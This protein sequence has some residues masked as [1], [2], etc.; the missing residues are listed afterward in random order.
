MRG[1]EEKEL[2][3]NWK[4]IKGG[5]V[6]EVIQEERISVPPHEGKLKIEN[7]RKYKKYSFFL[8]EI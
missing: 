7:I 4:E 3:R 6:R 8:G 1:I 5:H 2:R